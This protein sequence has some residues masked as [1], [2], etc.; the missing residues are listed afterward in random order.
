[1]SWAPYPGIGPAGTMFVA[2]H[3][4]LEFHPW[5][6][7]ATASEDAYSLFHKRSEAMGWLTTG[8]EGTPAGF[9]G[10][11]DAALDLDS[12]SQPPRVAWF[13]V[14][15]TEP[16]PAGRSLPLQPF[17]ACVDDVMAR[18]GRLRLEAIRVLLPM[19]SLPT[20]PSDNALGSYGWFNDADPHS[21]TRVRVTLDGGQDPSIRAAAPVM[22]Q[23]M[24]PPNV[25][26]VFRCD[27]VSLAADDAVVLE[28]GF[29]DGLWRGPGQHP[30]TFHGT[31]AEWSLDA[32]GWLAVFLADSASRHSITNPLMLTATRSEH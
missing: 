26:P 9:W 32:L 4:E 27:S 7:P 3:G 12:N 15:L 5:W 23:Q 16:I 21:R 2:L 30:A 8:L 10:M 17:L 29:T 14:G 11:N 1:M 19:H 22:L 18:M 24:L 20:P 6:D 13:Q 28:P 25:Q 31:L